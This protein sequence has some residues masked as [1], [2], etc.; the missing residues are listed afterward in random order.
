MSET[1]IVST[2][3]TPCAPG[4]G[5]PSGSGGVPS[6][7]SPACEA[8]AERAGPV[9]TRPVTAGEGPENET[10]LLVVEQGRAR[11]DRFMMMVVLFKR[12]TSCGVVGSGASDLGAESDRGVEIIA[13]RPP[14]PIACGMARRVRNLAGDRRERMSS[15]RPGRQ[16][17]EEISHGHGW[18]IDGGRTVAAGVYRLRWYPP[19]PVSA[20]ACRSCPK[21]PRH[22]AGGEVN[23]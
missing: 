18:I 14:L 11:E 6:P 21:L 23:S 4:D 13:E 2:T 10:A 8:G 17:D 9:L 15:A 7:T 3:M 12:F 22:G 19:D 5:A 1:I 20:D 16:H